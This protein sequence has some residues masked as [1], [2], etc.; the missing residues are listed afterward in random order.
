MPK[1]YYKTLGVSNSASKDE[2]KQAYR[3]LAHQYHPD[4]SGGDEKKFKEINEAYSVLSNDEKRQ[5]YDRFGTAFEQGGQ[6]WGWQNY[7]GQGADFED[8]FSFFNQGSG[9]QRAYYSQNIDLDD[10]LSG[11]FGGMF[12]RRKS[13]GK[14]VILEMEIGLKDALKGIEK[15]VKLDDHNIRLKIKIKTPKHLTKEQERLIKELEE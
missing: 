4:K 9:G 6:N 14:N 3:R 2:I 13:R 12:T 10:L 15:D 7:S 11:L 5:Q 1:D 8:I